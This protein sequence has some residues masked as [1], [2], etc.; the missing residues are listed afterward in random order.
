[1]VDRIFLGFDVG[2]QPIFRLTKPGKDISSTDPEDFIL[3]ETSE[4]FR[5]AMQGFVTFTGSGSISVDI[6]SFDFT[7]P[8]Y[9]LLKDSLDYVPG[10][11]D[12]FAKLTNDLSSFS[13]TN[14]RGL[15]RTVDYKVFGNTM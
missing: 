7:D 12:Y 11:Y 5:P 2:G 10:Y 4:T 6:S 13:I 1:M 14:R 8:P 9:I 3:T 15:A